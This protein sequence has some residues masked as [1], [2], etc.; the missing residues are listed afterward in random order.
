[1]ILRQ[2]RNVRISIITKAENRDKF[3]LTTTHSADTN[4]DTL[5]HKIQLRD[6]YSAL[7]KLSHQC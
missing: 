3:R 1:M 2:Y 5:L 7:S 4:S 6:V